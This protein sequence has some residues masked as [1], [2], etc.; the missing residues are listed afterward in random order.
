MCKRC[1]GVWASRLRAKTGDSIALLRVSGVLSP[2]WRRRLW[3]WA[4]SHKCNTQALEERHARNQIASHATKLEYIQSRYVNSECRTISCSGANPRVADIIAAACSTDSA[5]AAPTTSTARTPAKN[6]FFA[7][8]VLQW[9]HRYCVKRDRAQGVLKQRVCDQAYWDKV[10]A[11]WHGLLAEEQQRHMDDFIAAKDKWQADVDLQ[12]HA[13]QPEPADAVP[14]PPPNAEEG[15]ALVLAGPPPGCQSTLR[16]G[17]AMVG[18]DAD[19]VALQVVAGVDIVTAPRPRPIAEVGKTPLSLAV[20][21][22]TMSTAGPKAPGGESRGFRPYEQE[23][24]NLCDGFARDRGSL[25]RRVV[26]D[27]KCLGMCP[28]KATAQQWCLFSQ[29][30]PELKARLKQKEMLRAMENKTLVL[31]VEVFK[32]SAVAPERFFGLP[33]V[34]FGSGVSEVM[35]ASVAVFFLVMINTAPPVNISEIQLRIRREAYSAP[36]KDCAHTKNVTHGPLDVGILEEFIA[37]C[38]AATDVR[39][40]SIRRL[41]VRWTPTAFDTMQVAGVE[42][43]WAVMTKKAVI[44]AAP[45]AAPLADDVDFAAAIG[46]RRSS[47]SSAAPAPAPQA[48]APAL[49]SGLESEIVVGDDGEIHEDAEM[50]EALAAALHLPAALGAEGSS[51]RSSSSSSSVTSTS[52]HG[53]SDEDEILG[54][55]GAAAPIAPPELADI[56]ERSLDDVKIKWFGGDQQVW[57]INAQGVKLRFLGTAKWVREHS[58]RLSC[59]LHRDCGMILYGRGAWEHVDKATETFFK[60]VACYRHDPEATRLHHCA[61]AQ[62]LKQEL[63]DA[64][65]LVRAAAMS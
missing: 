1:L 36:F 30:V 49:P 50:L 8:N 28:E 65:R 24:K 18:H 10:R 57:E 5:G 61:L 43:G 63:K 40:A 16:D 32:A 62:R 22:R 41:R 27:R 12:R 11:E 45:V 19:F 15:G 48:P 23:W 31:A 3:R 21:R 6:H 64:S 20:L 2:T 38:L 13:P 46:A 42:H 51:Q 47:R 14:P 52:T 44:L 53:D 37:Q 34:S 56:L 54:P 55:V 9:Y 7:K 25:P 4:S 59:H 58:V 26:Q 39:E 33:A 17:V 29:I 35:V 60:H